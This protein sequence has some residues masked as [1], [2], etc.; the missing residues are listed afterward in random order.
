MCRFCRLSERP[1][2]VRDM[3]ISKSFCCTLD[4]LNVFHYRRILAISFITQL[5]L[6]V[7]RELRPATYECYVISD[8]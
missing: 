3:D 2:L 6:V 5:G 4:E 1:I 7:L 8:S